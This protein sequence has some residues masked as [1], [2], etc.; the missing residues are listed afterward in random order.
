[1]I[2]WC[3]ALAWVGPQTPPVTKFSVKPS[4]TD[5][6][7]TTFD[8]DHTVYIDPSVAKKNELVLYLPGTNG[9]TANTSGFC[10]TAARLGFHVV[11]LMYPDSIPA[12]IARNNPDPNA[13]LNF[14]LEIIEGGDRSKYLEVDRANSIE[15][16]LVKLLAYLA[17]ER[18]T[19]GWGQFLQ[20]ANPNW[21]KIVVSGGS[22]AW[23]CLPDRDSP[24]RGGR[25]ALRRSRD[26]SRALN[27]PAAW[28]TKP[29][30]RRTGSSPLTTSRTSR[31]ATTRS[32]GRSAR[33][34][35][36]SPRPMSI[37]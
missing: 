26:F 30:P 22:Q 4:L 37:P 5:A 29:K 31:A 9:K 36:S 3:L 19:E 34:W 10:G 18:P 15:N 8:S 23:A 7:I 20:G 16:R 27:Q 32:N 21:E 35:A 33:R 28:Y 25:R 12:T 14:R 6:A 1:M 24:P 11:S 17:K 13:F 2:A